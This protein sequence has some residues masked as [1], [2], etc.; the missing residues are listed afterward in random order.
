[1]SKKFRGPQHIFDEKTIAQI[2]TFARCHCPDSEIAA[3]AGCSEKTLRRRFRVE[4]HE[5]REK[6]KANLRAMQYSQAMK[7][8]RAMLIWVGKQICGQRE[9]YHH[10]EDVKAKVITINKLNGDQT[11]FKTIIDKNKS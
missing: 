4:L 10:I 11:I 9:Q 3:F 1:M 2:K 7:G 8:D 6:G 5:E